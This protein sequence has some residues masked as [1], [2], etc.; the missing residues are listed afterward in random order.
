M[1]NNTRYHIYRKHI[2]VALFGD[3]LARKYRE[4]DTKKWL[5]RQEFVYLTLGL[6]N[7]NVDLSRDKANGIFHYRTLIFD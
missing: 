5:N 3:K 6:V 4:T 7:K 2:R 1:V